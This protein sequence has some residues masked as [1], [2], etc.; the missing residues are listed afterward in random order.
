[1]PSKRDKG[2]L[3]GGPMT[4]RYRES[5]ERELAKWMRN[6]ARRFLDEKE[7]ASKLDE[8]AQAWLHHRKK[9]E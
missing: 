5:E 2:S 8:V 3:T 6:E 9:G 4:P 7:P 1:M